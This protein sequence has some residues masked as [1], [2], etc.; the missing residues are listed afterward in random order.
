MR[1]RLH[2]L[3]LQSEPSG[4][5]ES[6][7]FKD[8]DTR[9]SFLHGN[10]TTMSSISKMELDRIVQQRLSPQYVSVHATDPEVRQYLLGRKRPDDVLGKMR[11]LAEHGIEL[12]AQIV[13]CPTINDGEVLKRTIDDLAEL[14]PGLTFGCGCSC[15]V[16]QTA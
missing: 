16:H 10:Y 8:E 12:H 13:L 5:R 1:Q 9:L 4:S 15:R 11:Y 7:F 14:Y 3:F 6:L 2:L